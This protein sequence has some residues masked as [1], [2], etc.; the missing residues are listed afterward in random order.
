[1]TISEHN[2]VKR[3]KMMASKDLGIDRNIEAFGFSELFTAVFENEQC[4]VHTNRYINSI[5]RQFAHNE[6]LEDECSVV[7]C[8]DLSHTNITNYAAKQLDWYLMNRLGWFERYQ[9]ALV[10]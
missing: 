8:L 7:E 10:H 1:M 2:I 5:I 9:Y 4:Q 6:M 3:W